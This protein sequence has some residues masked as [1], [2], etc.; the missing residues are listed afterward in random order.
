MDTICELPDCQVRVKPGQHGEPKRFC[1]TNHQQRAANINRGKIR[2][3]IRN[4]RTPVLCKLSECD[5]VIVPV[6]GVG[7]QKYCSTRHRERDHSRKRFATNPELVRAK[8]RAYMETDCGYSMHRA[9]SSLTGAKRRNAII[10]PSF[11][12]A[13]LAEIFL[14]TKRCPDCGKK[15]KDLH[16]RHIDHIRPIVFG[17]THCEANVQIIC[18]ACHRIK[19]NAEVRLI[20]KLA[21][22]KYDELALDS[23]EPGMIR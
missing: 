20:N 17:G 13:I 22:M 10:D 9:A 19:S 18:K 5:M 14:A 21:R 7:N 6:V 11:T 8:K 12:V 1:C 16:N 15:I 23:A 3:A 2:A 4:A